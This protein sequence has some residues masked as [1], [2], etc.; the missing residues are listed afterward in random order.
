M[1]TST[2]RS[3]FVLVLMVG[4]LS[5]E[6]SYAQSN[7]DIYAIIESKN[8]NFQKSFNSKEINGLLNIYDDNAC[9][10][11]LG[12]GKEIIAGYYSEVSQRLKI[13]EI[14]ITHVSVSDTIA[15]ETGTWIAT[16]GKNQSFVGTYYSKWKLT[17]NDWVIISDSSVPFK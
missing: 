1:K 3:L 5:I 10:V 9:I 13:N 6:K 8:D 7:Q 12:C 2:T 16:T 17:N 14:N 15:I 4:F 11:S